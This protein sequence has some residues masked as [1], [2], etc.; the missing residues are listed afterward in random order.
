MEIDLVLAMEL[1]KLFPNFELNFGQVNFEFSFECSCACL[2]NNIWSNGKFYPR[3]FGNCSIRHSNYIFVRLSLL[4]FKYIYF[5]LVQFVSHVSS[6]ADMAD[7]L[8]YGVVSR[9]YWR[10]RVRVKF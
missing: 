9:M 3:T 1:I 2:I 6:L 4:T 7:A 8:C 5:N 10:T